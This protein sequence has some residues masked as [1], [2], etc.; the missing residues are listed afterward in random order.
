MSDDKRGDRA[1]SDPARLSTL[2]GAVLEL[3]PEERERWI[4]ES[5]AGN[6][7]LREQLR[8]MLRGA[9]AD[10]ANIPSQSETAF[11]LPSSGGRASGSGGS[12]GSGRGLPLVE[13]AGDRLVDRPARRPV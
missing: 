8:A 4:D 6:P 11:L 5:S 3:T 13:P 1:K 7:G 10:A 12:G 9:Q 2:L